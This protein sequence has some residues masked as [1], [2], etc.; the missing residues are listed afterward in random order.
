MFVACVDLQ[1]ACE[2]GGTQM[3]AIGLAL[4]CRNFGVQFGCATTEERALIIP[5]SIDSA[6]T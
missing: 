1:M 5:H 6:S 2:L 3:T 4:F